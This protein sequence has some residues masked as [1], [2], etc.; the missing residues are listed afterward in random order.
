MTT[1]AWTG[2]ARLVSHDPSHPGGVDHGVMPGAGHGLLSSHPNE[3]N[4][5]LLAF[6]GGAGG[7]EHAAGAAGPA[8]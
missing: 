7:T 4:E 8:G 1:T 2:I 5:A 3:V 6:L